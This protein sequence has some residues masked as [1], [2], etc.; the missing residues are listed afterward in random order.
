MNLRRHRTAPSL[1][2]LLIACAVLLGVHQFLAWFARHEPRR[3][4]PHLAGVFY[5]GFVPG[6]DVWT[7]PPLLR[8]DPEVRRNWPRDKFGFRLQIE[9]GF[10][11]DTFS[12]Q[13]TKDMGQD[14]DT[15]ITLV[16]DEG[17]LDWIYELA[18]A[19]RF[20]EVTEPRPPYDARGF[21]YKDF[22][23]LHHNVV[24]LTVRFGDRERTLQ[25]DSG[26][27]VG[28]QY[29]EQW[30]RLWWVAEQMYHAVVFRPEYRALP[31]GRP[32]ILL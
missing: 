27:L 9:S 1:V 30:R 5:R 21:V 18:L 19:S 2:S 29:I 22:E 8:V 20:Y 23:L 25:W 7:A 17:E 28:Q 32:Y 16:I 6:V 15:T 11:I 10:T 3:P 4:A 24:T 12:G 14:P 26:L 31:K 13:V